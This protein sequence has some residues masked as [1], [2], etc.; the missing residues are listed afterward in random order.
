M[1][2]HSNTEREYGPNK[3]YSDEEDS[4]GRLQNVSKK[5]SKERE[6]RKTQGSP[7]PPLYKGAN[8]NQKVPEINQVANPEEAILF[9]SE[10]DPTGG[11]VLAEDT[12]ISCYGLT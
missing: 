7:I 4:E 6:R 9:G 8:G 11:E 1:Y 5:G 3:T 2:S 12:S 10:G